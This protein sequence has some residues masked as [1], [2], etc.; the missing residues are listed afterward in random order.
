MNA[1]FLRSVLSVVSVALL[2]QAVPAT[3]AG[4]RLDGEISG[5][6]LAPQSLVGAAVFIFDYE[7]LVDGRMRRGWGWV[8]V[9]HEDLPVVEGESSLIVG[10]FGAIHVG[11]QRFDIEVNFG[12][13][14][15]TNINDPSEF[16]E[17]YEV[18]LSVDIRRF[19]GPPREHAFAGLLSHVPFP[20]IILGD[21]MPAP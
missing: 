9:N 8:A 5:I 13:L 15:L 10:G 1:R 6:E 16:D 19:F 17:D 11:L 21:L 2:L 14:T 4:P 7:G 18:L 20:P 12:S 3:A